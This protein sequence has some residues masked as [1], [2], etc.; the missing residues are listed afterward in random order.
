MLKTKKPFIYTVFFIFL[1]IILAG[2]QL[3]FGKKKQAA[4][5]ATSTPKATVFLDGKHLGQT[6]YNNDQLEP[7]DYDLKLVPES[8]GEEANLLSFQTK[9]KLVPEVMTV[10]NRDFGQSEQT[11]SG[12]V[13]YLEPVSGKTASI[14]VVTTPSNAV[15]RVDGEARGF[16][17][18]EIKEVEE[19]DYEITVSS[20]GYQE[21]SVKAKAVKGYKLNISLQ[22]AEEETEE[23][24]PSGDTED[25]ENTDSDQEDEAASEDE[26]KEAE[27]TLDKPYVKILDTPTGWLRVRM[28]PTTDST[29]SAKVNPGEA[30]PYLGESEEDEKSRVWHKIELDDEEGWVIGLYSEKVE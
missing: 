17:P 8:T 25:E 3:P 2:C 12:R 21:V 11:A 20:P 6:P 22:L 19:K 1:G 18:L 5:Q 15:V 23:A 16:S 13:L 4:L 9:I 14:A 7:G 24:S 27:I 10:V 28:E 26:E 30:Y 29:E